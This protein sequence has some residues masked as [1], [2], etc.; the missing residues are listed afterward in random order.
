MDPLLDF[1]GK[2]AIITGAA[3]G[4]GQL[5]AQELANRG[6]KLVIS[7]INEAGVHK[8]ADDIAA[9][10]AEILA[11]KCNVSKNDQCKLM[12][13]TAMEVFGR[14]DIGVNNAGVAHEF[15]P[16]HQID[17]SIMDSQFAVNVK[18]VQFGMRHQ[19]QQMLTQGEGVILNVSSMAGIGGAALGSAYSMAKHAVIGLTKTAAVEYGRAN[20]RVNAIC[21][22]FTLTP[23]VTNFADAEQQQKMSRGAPMKRLGEPKEIV[24]VMLM[25]LSPAN[26]YMTGQCIA[27]DGGVSAL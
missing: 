13:D 9:T 3:Q 1:S 12:V 20:I 17:E 2:V 15:M 23:M 10:G 18:G 24:A 5:L 27:V 16:F 14:V 8:V 19:I 22:F 11:M 4:F 26:T 7:D 6:A 25:M 21:P